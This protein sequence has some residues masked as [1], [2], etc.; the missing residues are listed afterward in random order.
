MSSAVYSAAMQAGGDGILTVDLTHSFNPLFG[1]LWIRGVALSLGVQAP[2]DAYQR[3][4]RATG[5][6][7]PPPAKNLVSP[8]AVSPRSPAILSTIFLNDPAVAPRMYRG[9]NINNLDPRGVW[10]IIINKNFSVAD[11]R[12]HARDP[13]YIT[14]I[15]LHLLLTGRPNQSVTAWQ[16]LTF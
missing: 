13:G 1:R 16:Q 9:A 12:Q 14:D 4:F 2:Q 6:V 15:K 3:L 10:T 5:Q 8:R 7:F 11:S